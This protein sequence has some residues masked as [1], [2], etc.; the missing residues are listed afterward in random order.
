MSSL[1][2]N[3]PYLLPRLVRHILPEK[4]VRALLLRNLVIRPGLETSNPFAAVQRYADVPS[5]Q[6]HSLKNASWSLAMVGGS[7]LASGC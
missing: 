7:I 1:Y 3:L 4:L 6:S 5:A 2:L